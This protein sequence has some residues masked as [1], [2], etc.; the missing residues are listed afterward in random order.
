MAEGKI[1]MVKQREKPTKI[2]TRGDED[3]A[4]VAPGVT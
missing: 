3:E 1:T 4:R 2:L